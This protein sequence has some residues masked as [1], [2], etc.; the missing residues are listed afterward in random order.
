MTFAFPYLTL[1]Q[2]RFGPY[3]P[4]RSWL[5]LHITGGMVALLIGPAQLWL[6]LT[7]QRMRLHR[8]LGTGYMTS[9]AISSMAAF[10]LAVHAT[11]E[12]G[13][14]HSTGVY[15]VPCLPTSIGTC[16]IVCGRSGMRGWAGS[17]AMPTI[18]LASAVRSS[19]RRSAAG[20]NV[21]RIE[22]R[23]GVRWQSPRRGS[24][25]RSA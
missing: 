1:D 16:W 23:G 7:R 15:A 21:G 2:Q 19:R 17:I 5:L 12:V 18:S 3:W 8:P 11:H 10:Y 25:G 4:R 20:A 13:G 24:V 6:G 14:D 22:G 9:V